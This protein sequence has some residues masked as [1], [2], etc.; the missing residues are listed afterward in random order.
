MLRFTRVRRLSVLQTCTAKNS[1]LT[2]KSSGKLT[3]GTY[4]V[5]V[6]RGTKYSSGYYK[7]YWKYY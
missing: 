7:M 6:S 1:D 4:Y 3:P 5:K 2:L